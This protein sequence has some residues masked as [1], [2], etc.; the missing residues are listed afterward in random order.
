MIKHCHSSDTQQAHPCVLD[1]DIP[2]TN[3]HLHAVLNPVNFRVS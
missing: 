3:G 1:R 2:V